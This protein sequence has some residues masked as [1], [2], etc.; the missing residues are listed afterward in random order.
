MEK[1]K[2][3]TWES[4]LALLRHLLTEWQGNGSIP[5]GVTNTAH[6]L[7]DAIEKEYRQGLFGDGLVALNMGNQAVLM[8]VFANF[9]A[10]MAQQGYRRDQLE[11][12]VAKTCDLHSLCAEVTLERKM[13]QD[14]DEGE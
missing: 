6:E 12:I 14:N 13:G 3:K 4:P 2:D 1:K 11:A 9:V 7:V 8:A 5:N 10:L